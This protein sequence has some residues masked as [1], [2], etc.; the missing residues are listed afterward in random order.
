MSWQKLGAIF[1]LIIC[2]TALSPGPAAAR[3]VNLADYLA[4]GEIGPDP[5]AVSQVWNY[6]YTSGT[7]L[8]QTFTVNL[9]GSV[10]PVTGVQHRIY[11]NGNGSP[12]LE[13]Y[14]KPKSLTIVPSGTR[15]GFNIT[16][17][18]V[19][20][21]NDKQV[22]HGL[23]Y[24][25][26][27][28]FRRECDEPLPYKGNFLMIVV[29]DKTLTGDPLL[30]GSSYLGIPPDLQEKRVLG[31]SF[32]ASGVGEIFHREFYYENNQHIANAGDYTYKLL[33]TSAP[34]P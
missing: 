12:Y 17:Q 26:V 10:D 27:L 18:E 1:V 23:R 31:Y 32:F 11:K 34:A 25:W 16:D 2:L 20:R 33:S 13:C 30:N 24:A 9:Q 15:E 3:P 28:D 29:I 14:V 21:L 7:N 6:Q 8:G 19:S 5:E 4:P 22:F